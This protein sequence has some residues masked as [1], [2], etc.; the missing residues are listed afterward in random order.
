MWKEVGVAT[1]IKRSS[2]P[3]AAPNGTNLAPLIVRVPRAPSYTNLGDVSA[4]TRGRMI[5][6]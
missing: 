6:C 3:P 5:L 2:R 4:S 1:G